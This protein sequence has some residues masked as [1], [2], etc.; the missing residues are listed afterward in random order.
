M[1]VENTSLYFPVTL[2]PIGL[3]EVFCFALGRDILFLWACRI[4]LC[5]VVVHRSTT[6]TFFSV[7]T[8][9]VL[10]IA[11]VRPLAILIHA[12]TIVDDIKRT[13]GSIEVLCVADV[14]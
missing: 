11:V 13:R 5:T 6:T 14:A 3:P 9:F 1:H 4:F 10:G 7:Q 8:V 12:Y 2:F